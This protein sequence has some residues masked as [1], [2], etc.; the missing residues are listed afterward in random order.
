MAFLFYFIFIKA[1]ISTMLLLFLKIK[2][3]IYLFRAPLGLRCRTWA[4]S[5]CGKQELLFIAVC[6][7]LVAVASLVVEH[8]L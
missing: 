4:F 8:E 3:F 1:R 5:I 6:G 7:L 2:K